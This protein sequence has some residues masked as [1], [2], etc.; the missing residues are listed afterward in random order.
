MGNGKIE[1][2]G[3]VFGPWIGIVVQDNGMGMY[4]VDLQKIREF[5]PGKTTKEGIGTGFGLPIARRNIEAH[6]GTIDI[7]SVAD[8]G[9][10]VTIALPRDYKPP[11]HTTEKE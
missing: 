6:G 2:N 4:D 8:Q 10:T 5:I 1:I 9:T 3:R 7:E 11:R